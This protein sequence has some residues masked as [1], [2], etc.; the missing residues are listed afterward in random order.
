VAGTYGDRTIWEHAYTGIFEHFYFYDLVDDAPGTGTLAQYTAKSNHEQNFGL[1]RM[2]WSRKPIFNAVRNALTLM[3]DPGAVFTLRGIRIKFAGG[4]SS[5]KYLLYEKRDGSHRVVMWRDVKIWNPALA[6]G[7]TATVSPATLSI[8]VT[9][10][11]TRTVTQYIPSVNSTP[12]V[13]ASAQKSF[14]VTLGAG[15]VVLKIDP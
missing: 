10:G 5:F 9:L 2:D 7:T 11:R 15:A 4:D 12:S 14:T 8:T 13:A 1:C 6:G 3:E